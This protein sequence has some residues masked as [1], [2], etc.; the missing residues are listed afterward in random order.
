M[1]SIYSVDSIYNVDSIRCVLYC[2]V[3]HL[4]NILY[5][6]Y[7]T[8]QHLGNILYVFFAQCNTWVIFCVHSFELMMRNLFS[9]RI[10]IFIKILIFKF[11]Q[12]P[13]SFVYKTWIANQIY[14]KLTLP[15]KTWC[16]TLSAE[17]ASG[18]HH[19][20]SAAAH[21]LDQA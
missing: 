18:V 21:G 17:V 12:L 14:L 2:T 11:G 20:I 5:V 19:E 1:D 15:I 13:E 8:V 3:Q 9:K 10:L 4:G 6:F 16:Q 7:C